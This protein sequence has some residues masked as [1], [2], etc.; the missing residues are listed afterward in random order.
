MFTSLHCSMSQYYQY[1]SG[2]PT[3]RQQ[4]A[5]FYKATLRNAVIQN[6]L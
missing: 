3:E 6:D 5:N 2:K 1:L 4:L